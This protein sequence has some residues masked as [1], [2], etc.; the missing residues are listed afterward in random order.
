MLGGNRTAIN[1]SRF[2]S[3]NLPASRCV[4]YEEYKRPAPD[5]DEQTTIISI[6]TDNWSGS[7][8]GSISFALAAYLRSNSSANFVKRNCGLKFVI[9]GSHMTLVYGLWSLAVRASGDS[10]SMMS[11]QLAV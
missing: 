7:V 3:V 1:G 4:D 9:A 10:I 11:K 5:E 8:F 2:H 6:V